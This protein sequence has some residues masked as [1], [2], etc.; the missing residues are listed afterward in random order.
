MSK[1]IDINTGKEYDEIP[2]GKVQPLI[3]NNQAVTEEA[4]DRYYDQHPIE[5]EELIVVPEQKSTYN[6][7]EIPMFS[8]T[9]TKMLQMHPDAAEK[10][11]SPVQT[12][13]DFFKIST[14]NIL[15]LLLPSHLVGLGA[16]AVNGENINPLDYSSKWYENDGLGEIQSLKDNE[17]TEYLNLLLD[18]G[19]GVG[20]GKGLPKLQKYLDAR[21]NEWLFVGEGAESKVFRI[22]KD[23]DNVI[24]LTDTISPEEMNTLQKEI[25]GFA[26]TKYK[27][28]TS[29][30][31]WEYLQKRLST[32]NKIFDNIKAS[33]FMKRNG[34][35]PLYD[36]GILTFFNPERQLRFVDIKASNWGYDQ[37]GRYRPL[38]GYL[39]AENDYQATFRKQGG[40][41]IFKKFKFGGQI[42]KFEDGGYIPSNDVLNYIKS[43]EKF[44]SKWYKDGNGYWTIGYGFTE[45][46][47]PELRKLYPKGMTQKQAEDYFQK[48]INDSI[49]K[50]IELTPNFD[51]LNQNQKDALFSYYYNIGQGGYTRKSPSLQRALREQNWKEVENNIDFGYYDKKNKGLRKRREAERRR[52]RTPLENIQ[53]NFDINNPFGLKENPWIM[54]P[55]YF[56]NK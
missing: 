46:D 32:R 17:Y 27:G 28:R 50:F 48:I 31:N 25:K 11:H 36:K 49:S 1:Y 40:K 47:H 24:K 15:D 10:A 42:Y 44:N 16:S 7:W 34:F 39:L 6:P 12:F 23:K 53:E 54:I 43:I 14:G 41:L 19:V 37:I 51:K 2:K 33:R 3:V 52:F 55:N 18:L 35:I 45:K 29:E 8:S 26:S 9:R 21:G 56:E 38:D 5:L 20:I 22:R 30:G 13:N 4:H